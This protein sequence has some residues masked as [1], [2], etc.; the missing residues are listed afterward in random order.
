MAFIKIKKNEDGEYYYYV[1]SY[2]IGDRVFQKNL[3]YI[4][5]EKPD[6]NKIIELENE[7]TE[8]KIQKLIRS[9]LKF[10][11]YKVELDLIE[12]AENLKRK[13]FK[14]LEKMSPESKRQLEKRFKTGF[15]YHSCSIEG[16]T[17]SRAQVD[18]VINQNISIEGKR[19]LEIDE[20]RNHKKAIDY[21]MSEQEDLSENFIKRL[22]EILMK[23]LNEYIEDDIYFVIGGYR[24]DMRYIE[25][26]DFI[27]VPPLMIVD[28]M[29]KLISFYKK[30]K[31]KIHPLELAAEFHL[32]FVTIHPFSDG[33]GRMAR[34]LMNFIL[35]RSGFPMI[36]ILLEN[37]QKYINSLA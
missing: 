5:K 11:K 19:L 17:L 15:T 30:N 20:L 22:H 23:D 3:K 6:E 28:E 27:P 9:D 10:D 7:F 8:K 12:K 25:G 33:N 29:R 32:K 2:R 24:C 34:L 14:N 18:M 13:F 31:Y 1:E 36:D 16:N 21:M 37:R 35:D 26:A 4:G